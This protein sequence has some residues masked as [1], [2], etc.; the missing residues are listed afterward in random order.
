MALTEILDYDSEYREAL[1]EK[2]KEYNIDTKIINDDTQLRNIS[3][4]DSLNFLQINMD[5][6]DKF[7]IDLK[8]E[9]YNDRSTI[10]DWIKYIENSKKNFE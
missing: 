7:N 2:L 1:F 8:N 5:I 10:G 6:E 9:D 3:Q 4:L